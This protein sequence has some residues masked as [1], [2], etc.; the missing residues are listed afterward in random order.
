MFSIISLRA[1]YLLGNTGGSMVCWGRF[2]TCVAYLQLSEVHLR[3]LNEVHQQLT[4]SSTVSLYWLSA[5]LFWIWILHSLKKVS[6]KEL[7]LGD[8]DSIKCGLI[9]FINNSSPGYASWVATNLFLWWKVDRTKLKTKAHFFLVAT[10]ISISYHT[11]HL[12]T[13]FVAVVE[14]IFRFLEGRQKSIR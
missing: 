5:K 4:L 1:W 10:W 12:W 8:L 6:T 2:D 13:I 7:I 3:V 11:K 14:R 9:L